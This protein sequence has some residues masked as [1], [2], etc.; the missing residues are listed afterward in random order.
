[1]Q[2]ERRIAGDRRVLGVRLRVVEQDHALPQRGGEALFFRVCNLTDERFV[3]P[4]LRVRVAEPLDHARDHLVEDPALDAQS[5]R[6]GDH[7]PQHATQDVAAPGVR[8]LDPVGD[9]ERRRPPVLGDD[10][11]RDVVVRI[12]AV[13]PAGEPLGDLERRAEQIR[14]EDVV[15]ALQHRRHSLERRTGV[16]VLARQ[17]RDD[18]EIGVDLVLDEHEVPDLHEALLVDVGSAVGSV[19]RST[20]HEDLAAGAGRPGGVRRPVVGGLA[21][22]VEHP[23]P[24]DPVRG[25][26]R[27]IDPGRDRFLVIVEHGDPQAIMLDPVALRDQLVCPPDGV[28]LEVVREREVAEHLEEREVPS[29]LSDVL[30]V[31]G[32]HDLLGGRR[33]D[34]TAAPSVRGST[35]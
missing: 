7:A 30:D 29:I 11:E 19:L 18:G 32:T 16:D 24:D 2:L 8:R 31:V 17:R 12:L 23:P 28:D 6:V 22:G 35:G 27:D 1:M 33:A 13:L 26:P 34:G 25:E 20:I 14:F 15:D 5:A 9:Q 4:E 21:L 3:L 10:L